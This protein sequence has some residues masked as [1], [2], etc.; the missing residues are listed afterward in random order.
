MNFAFVLWEGFVFTLWNYLT[1]I[2]NLMKTTVNTFRKKGRIYLAMAAVFVLMGWM[3]GIAQSPCGTIIAFDENATLPL[4]AS[5]QSVYFAFQVTGCPGGY[6]PGLLSV[7]DDQ[8]QLGFTQDFLQ[9][10]NGLLFVAYRIDVPGPGVYVLELQYGDADEVEV[11]LNVIQAPDNIP[12]TIIYPAQEIALDVDPC[13]E[14]GVGITLFEVSA[15]D[16]CGMDLDPVIDVV[17]AGATVTQAPGGLGGATYLFTGLPGTYQIQITA[18][19]GS[20]NVRQ[21]DFQVTVSQEDAPEDVLGCDG[22]VVSLDENCQY[23][24]DPEFILDGNF[25][26]LTPDDFDVLVI[27]GDLSNGNIVDGVG[28]YPVL[29]TLA[30]NGATA[31]FKGYFNPLHWT[32]LEQAGGKTS[33]AGDGSGLTF[34]GP[35]AGSCPLGAQASA[36]IAIPSTGTL[37]FDYEYSGMDDQGTGPSAFFAVVGASG[38][39]QFLANTLVDVQS[40]GSISVDLQAGEVLLC[41]IISFS[42]GGSSGTAAISNFVF[43]PASLDANFTECTGNVLAEDDLP[44]DLV[45]PPDTD[46]A[47]VSTA[48]QQ[49]DGELEPSDASLEL[50]DY[51]CFLDLTNPAPGEQYYDLY[52]FSVSAPAVYTFELNT[53][54]GDGL[55]ALY[56]GDFNPASP[57]SNIIAQSDDILAGNGFTGSPDPVFRLALPLEPGRTYTLLTSSFDAEV[58]GD[59]QWTVFSDDMMGVIEGVPMAMTDLTFDLFC[60]DL[61]MVFNNPSSLDYTGAPQVSDN[62]DAVSVSFEDEWIAGE[63]CEADIIRRTFTSTDLSGNTNTCVQEITFRRPSFDDVLLPPYTSY[64]ECDESYPQDENGNVH[65]SLS[66][67]PFL[68]TAFGIYDLDDVVCTLGGEYFDFPRVDVCEGSFQYLR[69]WTLFDLCNPGSNFTYNQT[70]L[71]GDFTAPEISCPDEDLFGTGPFNCTA[72]LDVPLPVVSDN[73]SDW[74]VTTEIVTDTVVEV[75]NEFDQLIGLDTQDLV[76]AVLL[77]GQPR[78]ASGIPVGDH[79]FRYTVTD[80]CENTAVAECPFSVIDLIEPV[81]VCDD[82]LTVSLNGQGLGRLFAEDVDEGSWDN[83]ELAG[84]DLRREI[85][86]GVFSEWAPFVDF[87]CADVD[88]MIAIELRVTDIY[89]NFNTCPTMVLVRDLLQP[90]CFAPD[91]VSVAC[92]ELPFDFDQLDSAQLADLYGTAMATDNCGASVEELSPQLT[93]DPT[94]G[95][96][97]LIRTFRA[98]DLFGNVSSNICRQVIEVERASN[99]A[100]KFP[101]D[102]E[103]NCMQ[104]TPDTIEIVEIGC[105]LLAVFV[106]DAPFSASQDECYKVLRT[107]RVLNWCEWDGISDPIVV[108]REED[109]DGQPGDEDIWVLVRDGDTYYDRD[110]DETNAEPAANS[111][112]LSC[113]GRSNPKGYWLDDMLD[114]AIRSV[115]Y[116]QYTQVIKVFDDT[117]PAITFSPQDS[118]CTVSNQTCEGPVD[119]DFTLDEACTQEDVTVEVELDAGRDGLI[120]AGLF[121]AFGGTVTGSYPNFTIEGSFP[122]GKHAF[123]L[124]V[125]DACGNLA[126]RTLPFEVVDCVAPAP[127]CIFGL[128]AEL[129]P[130]PPGTDAD[131]DGDVDAGALTLL[132]EQFL[133]ATSMDCTEPVSVSI[134]RVGETPVQDQDRLIITCD[135]EGSLAIEIHAWDAAGNSDFCETF[136]MIEDNMDICETGNLV[137]NVAGTLHTP[138]MEGLEGAEVLLSGNDLK[139][140]LSGLDGGYLFEMVPMGSDCTITPMHDGDDLNGVSTFD[141][142]MISKHILSVE[143]LY[144]PYQLI[145]ADVNNS[146]TIT[147]LDLV[148][149]RRLI[150]NVDQ[151]LVFNTSWRF[152]DAAYEFPDP[153]NPWLEP[154]P[155]VINLNDLADDELNNDFIA[156][157]IGD[158]SGNAMPN[159]QALQGRSYVGSLVLKAEDQSLEA[160]QRCEVPIR[161]EDLQAIDGYQFSLSFDPESLRLV[162]VRHGI[163]TDEHF[164]FALLNEGA[165]TTSWNPEGD[166]RPEP[167]EVLFTLVLEARRSGSLKDLLRIG[168]RY[169]PAEAYTAQGELLDV[170]LQFGGEQVL[171]DSYALYQNQPNPWRGQTQIGF[172]L[173][174]A[175]EVLLSVRDASGR[176]LK[177]VRGEFGAGTHQVRIEADQLPSGVLYYTLETPHFTDTKKMIVLKK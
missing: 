84:F 146:K 125:E 28:S 116:W 119:F 29:V 50:A 35:D 81:A 74:A 40:S 65:P 129:S 71:V 42:C 151:E 128:A 72:T 157:K 144:N 156:V 41:G 70:I 36:A 20:G 111:K 33:F 2:V 115:G 161:A 14:G 175:S 155:E 88:S 112:G 34:T 9:E 51:A 92:D 96:G 18:T 147:T 79:R 6:D 17:P 54:W 176:M 7:S 105:D 13:D 60:T 53:S 97:L 52:T 93:V 127:T 171:S 150:L 46:E 15:Y 76:L 58:T 69:Q 133:V 139:T 44:P 16:N 103:A 100:I 137:A 26:C 47:T 80:D 152:V 10:E 101:K 153:S 67:Y 91:N 68:Q 8:G 5:E 64:V 98:T 75:F 165:L 22:V 19:D 109:C 63:D 148:Q 168:T 30:A 108:S 134:N 43:T 114:P 163:T 170:A 87:D 167:E 57:C 162:D 66:G 61:T 24:I 38:S 4:C 138:Y 118:F 90:F 124:R 83:C 149:L 59:Y 32:I 3:R 21:E 158:V 78:I 99:Y 145:A 130:L 113:D 174:V 154:I 31:G 117:P 25:G 173:P 131:G 159:S 27:D 37:Q 104:P 135:E 45:C 121:Q 89:G 107:Y 143:P 172:Y 11:V 73:C 1:L 82:D 86:P 122:V 95:D 85:A 94:C 49:L 166:F 55:A 62:C 164:G 12:P 56:Q 110:E 120:D 23:K 169:T 123:V 102:A 39:F 140:T 141:L 136:V 142:V 48:V 160:G 132:A 126:Q 77:P 177:L 106:E